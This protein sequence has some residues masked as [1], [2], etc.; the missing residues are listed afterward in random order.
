MA[1]PKA[2]TVP[3]MQTRSPAA[4]KPAAVAP[5]DVPGQV[6]DLVPPRVDEDDGATAL[7]AVLSELGG[8]DNG[9]VGVYRIDRAG[10]LEYVATLTPDE[11]Q[12]EASL[13]EAIRRD[14]GGGSYRIHVRDAAGLIANRRV[15]IAERKA[16]DPS[17]AGHQM[18]AVMERMQ[19]QFAQALQA[20]TLAQRP[21]VSEAD[22]EEKV[23]ARMQTMANILGTRSSG[24]DTSVVME[25]LSQ[26]IEL[27]KQLGGAAAGGQDSTG[28]VMAESLKAFTAMMLAQQ[29]APVRRPVPVPARQVAAVPPQPVPQPEG[30]ATTAADGADELAA[31]RTLLQVVMTGA[32]RESDPEL[33]AELV[34][35]QLGDEGVNELLR[36]PDPVALLVQ[37]EP[38]ADEHR[39]WLQALAD[40][41]RV[42]QEE[43]RAADGDTTAAGPERADGHTGRPGRGAADARAHAGVGA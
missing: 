29:R 9:R 16:P 13:L 37:L 10:G 34:A 30:P 25:T 35:D 3:G 27:G 32:R 1:N 7:D 36:L 39:T 23:L 31:M 42:L 28:A 6:I 24:I 22:A 17:G 14:Y 21:A 40:A 26:G 43:Q 19:A 4:R 5:I 18:V 33:Y 12:G 41:L 38:E 8:I 20:M 15:S 2:R 11:V